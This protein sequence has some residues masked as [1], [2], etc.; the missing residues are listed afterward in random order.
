MI[1][2]ICQN[3]FSFLSKYQEIEHF[4]SIIYGLSALLA[5]QNLPN[6]IKGNIPK[7]LEMLVLNMKRYTRDRVGELRMELEDK[8]PEIPDPDKDTSEIQ[9]AVNKLRGKL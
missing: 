8:K 6:L 1:L 5:T 4:R 7:I 2:P 9:S 3:F